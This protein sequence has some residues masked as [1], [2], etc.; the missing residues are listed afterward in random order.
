MWAGGPGF[1]CR[2]RQY[3]SGSHVTSYR[4]STTCRAW[5]RYISL[6]PGL[7]GTQ[8]HFLFPMYVMTWHVK[9]LSYLDGWSVLC[10]AHTHDEQHHILEK[11]CGNLNTSLGTDECH[12]AEWDVSHLQF[13]THGQHCLLQSVQYL[14]S[15]GYQIDYVEHLNTA[16]WTFKSSRSNVSCNNLCSSVVPF[17]LPCHSD[18]TWPTQYLA[19]LLHEHMPEGICSARIGDR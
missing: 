2:N 7:R 12:V 14:S 6:V 13:C 10:K 9:N 16:L 11:E 19:F 4:T 5:S 17:Q 1:I 15:L 3:I 8:L 18:R